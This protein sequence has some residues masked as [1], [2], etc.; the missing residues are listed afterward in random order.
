M[1]KSAG[2]KPLF[3]AVSTALALTVTMAQ[4]ASRAESPNDILIIANSSVNAEKISTDDLVAIFLRKMESFGGGRV[5]PINAK[6]GTAARKAFQAKVL[7]MDGASES[8]YWEEQ[9]IKSGLTPPVEF[10][11]TVRAVF[12]MKGSIGYC[13]RSEFKE[14]VV[15]I[16]LVL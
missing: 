13:R 3:I 6:G 4:S 2:L 9:K 15:K 5:I 16:L 1:T 11:E 7:G 12:H 10:A 14:G 8:G